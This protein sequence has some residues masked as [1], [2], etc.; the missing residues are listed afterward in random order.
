M[1][2]RYAQSVSELRAQTAAIQR[3]WEAEREVIL[4]RWGDSAEQRAHERDT[5]LACLDA[6]RQFQRTSNKAFV[7]EL[8]LVLDD[9]VT[10]EERLK[11]Q[12]ARLEGVLA[13]LQQAVEDGKPEDHEEEEE[14]EEDEL[15]VATTELGAV[16]GELRSLVQPVIVDN[17]DETS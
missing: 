9:Q 2:S 6:E 13:T 3:R 17:H 1:S 5:L 14:E 8:Q 11:Q 4:Q 15:A 16:L 10:R 7:Q 12:V